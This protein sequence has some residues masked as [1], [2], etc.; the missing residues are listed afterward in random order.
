MSRPKLQHVCESE[1]FLDFLRRTDL[2]LLCAITLSYMPFCVCSLPPLGTGKLILLGFVY[3]R[4]LMAPITWG[5]L[6]KCLWGCCAWSWS[7]LRYLSG[8]FS[9]LE[10]METVIW[11]PEPCL[12][13]WSLLCEYSAKQWWD[14]SLSV[15]GRRAQKCMKGTGVEESLSVPLEERVAMPGPH[16][17][18]VSRHSGATSLRQ[19]CGI[20]LPLTVRTWLLKPEMW[21]L[22]LKI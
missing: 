17:F 19:G 8:S 13:F 11:R 15:V 2:S 16:L 1:T 6:K 22:R 18:S 9:F 12:R 5:A 7:E 20:E 3:L 14:K 10:K 21:P 4:F